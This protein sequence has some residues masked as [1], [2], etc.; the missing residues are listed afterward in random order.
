MEL[1]IDKHPI[2]YLFGPYLRAAI[3]KYQNVLHGHWIRHLPQ[4]RKKNKP[5][6]FVWNWLLASKLS[7]FTWCR[8]SKFHFMIAAAETPSK[9][10]LQLEIVIVSSA[11]FIMLSAE[12]SFPHTANILSTTLYFPYYADILILRTSHICHDRKQ[13]YSI[14]NTLISSNF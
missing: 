12:F 13:H 7:V 14:M 4:N 10:K 2:F 5:L 3:W 11:F 8:H 6:T 9:N 1:S